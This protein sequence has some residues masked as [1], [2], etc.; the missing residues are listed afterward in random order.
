MAKTLSGKLLRFAA[1]VFCAGVLVAGMS[2]NARANDMNHGTMVTFTS[3]VEV[4]APNG[5]IVLSPGKYVFEVT[6]T[7]GDN[8]IVQ[9]FNEDITHVYATVL[10]IRSYRAAPGATEFT[11][12]QRPGETAQQ[13][14]TWFY[15]DYGYGQEFVYAQER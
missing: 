1:V 6:G 11:L 10:A 8:I 3:A 5:V 14:K 4:P 15:R 9:I 12:V 7:R 13:I 2:L